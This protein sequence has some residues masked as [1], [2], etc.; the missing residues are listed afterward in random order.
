METDNTKSLLAEGA[1][2]QLALDVTMPTPWIWLQ[3]TRWKLKD[4]L[5]T[6][7]REEADTLLSFALDAINRKQFES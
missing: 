7:E 1:E 4:T 2:A 6:G 3:R 5:L